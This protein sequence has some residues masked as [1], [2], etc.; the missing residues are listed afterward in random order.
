MAWSTR[1]LAELAGTTVK[2]VRHYHKVGLLEEPE[3]ASNGYKK[4]R[5]AHLVRLLQIR[6]LSDLGVPLPQIA[7]M[8]IAPDSPAEAIRVVDAELAAS[9]ERLQRVRAELAVILRHQATGDVPAD[10]DPI[11]HQMSG[12]DRAMIQVFSR[13]FSDEVMTEVRD[14]AG[15]ARHA[16]DDEFDALPADADEETI[17]DLGER[18]VPIVRESM[19]AYPRFGDA[20]VDSP[21]GPSVAGSAIVQ[22][23]VDL[24]NPAQLRV[25]QII[26][27]AIR[28]NAGAQ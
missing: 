27:R 11:G 21:F 18:L 28:G 6:R 4:Y 23:M 25:L 20:A 8:E 12:A 14:L 15:K 1:E 10:F 13:V 5:T 17:R 3:R 26:N 19:V 16:T 22:A 2:A 24:Y 7:A 9:I